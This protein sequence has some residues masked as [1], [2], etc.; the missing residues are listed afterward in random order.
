V[1]FCIGDKV[2]DHFGL[3][4]QWNEFVKNPEPRYPIND[5]SYEAYDPEADSPIEGIFVAGWS[6]E[7]SSGLVG[8]ARKDGECGARAMLQYLEGVPPAQDIAGALEKVDQVMGELPHPVVDKKGVQKLEA[9]EYAEAEKQG[10]EAF[11]YGSNEK[12]LSLLSE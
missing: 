7:A 6:R 12:M 9:L 5:L 11:K 4:I 2:D 8:I 10:L 1:V 3:P